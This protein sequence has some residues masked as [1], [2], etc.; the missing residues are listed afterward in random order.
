VVTGD[1][2]H[3]WLPEKKGLS[4]ADGKPGIADFSMSQDNSTEPRQTP[5]LINFGNQVEKILAFEMPE[6]FFEHQA[7][8]AP[9]NSL[10]KLT[11]E[12]QISLYAALYDSA[13]NP[14]SP[15]E[16]VLA[17][18]RSLQLRVCPHSTY[19]SF[20]PAIYQSSDFTRRFLAIFEQGFDPTVQ[21]MD[22]LW[23]YLDPL[24]APRALLPFLAQWVAWPWD[25][26]L[27]PDKQR[28]LLRHAIT[29]YRCRGTRYG[30]RLY[31]HLYTRLPLDDDTVPESQKCI[32]VVENHRPNFALGNAELAHAPMLG[33]GRP[34]HFTVVL[35]PRGQIDLSKVELDR[36]ID[37]I[38][39]AYCTYDSSIEPPSLVHGSQ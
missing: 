15:R 24:T 26:H 21:T 25:P 39:P 19:A 16:I 36:L 2:P 20:L 30:L 13:Q 5:R 32:S 22:N 34:F 7:N 6:N 27:D 29:L 8:S 10:P 14:E 31:L 37:Q 35:R 3:D 4:P 9:D 1:F 18:F 17:G 33:G 12:A 38:K 11:Y 23:A 28:H